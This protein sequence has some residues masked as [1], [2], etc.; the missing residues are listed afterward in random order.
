[1]NGLDISL[2]NECGVEYDD[3]FNDNNNLKRSD[4]ETRHTCI[5]CGRKRYKS[6]MKRVLNKSWACS[7]NKYNFRAYCYEHSDIKLAER[8][9]EDI[10]KIKN[11]TVRSVLK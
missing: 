6:S 1:M 4:F 5:I 2:A 9:L 7:D 10:S 11:Q 8:I 3:F